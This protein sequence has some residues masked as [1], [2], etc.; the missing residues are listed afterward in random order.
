MD[1][2]QFD[3][4]RKYYS[5]ALKQRE[6]LLADDPRNVQAQRDL[7]IGYERL[8][9]VNRRL[10]NLVAGREYY[11]KALELCQKAVAADKDN[12]DARIDLAGAYGNLGYVNME[13]K[14]YAEAI[15]WFEKSSQLLQELD[16]QGKIKAQPLYQAWLK[17]HRAQ[18]AV[19]KAAERAIADLNFALAQPVA[20]ALD[21]LTIRATVLAE[22]GQHVQAAE[23]AE[24]LRGLAPKD[25]NVLY[26]VACSYALCVPG[27]ARGKKPDQLTAEEAD[28]RRRYATHACA[29]LN[30]AVRQGYK[31]VANMQHDPDLEA[32][33]Q[34]GDYQKLL[35]RLKLAA[36]AVKPASFEKPSQ[37]GANESQQQ[38]G[39]R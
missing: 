30:E 12:A 1:A 13:A 18:L 37:P 5:Q 38:P 33:R 25:P 27:V 31:D 22:R 26:N 7:S 11:H 10:G 4:A 39:P 35:V 15:P 23:T 17:N 3:A 16:A 20:Q 28:L 14:D 2:G 19:C 29:A 34:E 32:I 8:G 24:K 21:L 36:E 9:T 6:Q